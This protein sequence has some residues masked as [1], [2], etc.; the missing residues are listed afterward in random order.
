[1]GPG[2]KSQLALN[3]KAR[4]VDG[5]PEYSFYIC[6]LRKLFPEAL[7]IHIFRDVTSVV[8]S[9][10]HFHQPGGASLVANEQEA[11]NYWLGAVNNCVLAERAFGPQVVFRLR[12][13]D[14]TDNPESV[15]R[16]VFDFLDEPYAPECLTPLARRINSSNVP[17]DFKIDIRY[18]DPRIIERAE[19]LSRDTQEGLQ[20][21]E[22]SAAAVEEIEAAFDERI[23]LAATLRSQYSKAV[24]KI[25]ALKEKNRRTG[26]WAKELAKELEEKKAIIQHLRSGRYYKWLRSPLK[27]LHQTFRPGNR[28]AERQA[29][30]GYAQSN[31]PSSKQ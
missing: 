3:P 26:V 13:S 20:A 30:D 23:Q 7:F 21:L 10:L 29:S 14:L 8:R 9:M 25:V 4:W 16:S 15:L 31:A 17:A 22:A 5:T 18:T 28:K 24:K 12:Y 19:R 11:Y 27:T 1:M 2:T 6:G